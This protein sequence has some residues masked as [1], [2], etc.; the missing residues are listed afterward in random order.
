MK[1]KTVIKIGSKQTQL[2][3]RCPECN[4]P[5][6]IPKKMQYFDGCMNRYYYWEFAY[7][8]DCPKCYADW[9]FTR[10]KVDIPEEFRRIKTKNCVLYAFDIG[11]PSKK[12]K[13]QFDEIELYK[14]RIIE[15][16]YS[17]VAILEDY[18]QF[19]VEL[20]SDMWPNDDGR[21][22]WGDGYA[23]VYTNV[24]FEGN[25]ETGII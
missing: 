17:Y 19:L 24:D 14:H 6:K 16:R 15:K 1:E 21:F 20:H 13:F 22:R 8:V 7:F 5:V 23:Y 10:I 12:H 2:F 18:I 3:Q 4:T 25:V 11:L 9:K